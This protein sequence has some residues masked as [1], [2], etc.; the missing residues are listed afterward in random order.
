MFM[1][2]PVSQPVRLPS[3]HDSIHL[4]TGRR[5]ESEASQSNRYAVEQVNDERKRTAFTPGYG[6]G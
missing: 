5:E 2:E 3:R 6:A 4:I 1:L